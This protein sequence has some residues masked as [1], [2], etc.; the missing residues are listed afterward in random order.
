MTNRQDPAADIPDHR[1]LGRELR[2]MSLPVGTSVADLQHTVLYPGH[3]DVKLQGHFL[4]SWTLYAKHCHRIL[5]DTTIDA[6]GTQAY[7]HT[8]LLMGIRSLC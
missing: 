7:S 4:P 6:S 3:K 1:N 2:H 5:G 8:M